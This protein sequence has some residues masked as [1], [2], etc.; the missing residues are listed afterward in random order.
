MKIH[1]RLGDR[2]QHFETD[3]HLKMEAP[4]PSVTVVL[5]EAPGP[6][7]TVVLPIYRTAQRH[8][9]ENNNL[10]LHRHD[11]LNLTQVGHMS[12]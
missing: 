11:Y 12:K 8:I 5:P 9:Q 7:V 2:H 4:G 3:I 10:D 1:R 6:S